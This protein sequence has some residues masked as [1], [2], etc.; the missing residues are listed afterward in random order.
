MLLGMGGAKSEEVP[1]TVGDAKAAF[2]AAYGAPVGSM[3]QGFVNEMLTSVTLATVSA[4]Y[5]YTRVF[6]VGFETLCESFLAAV[7][8]EAQRSKIH[9]A[10]C[11]ALELDA[12]KVVQDAAA[13][14]E[15]AGSMTEEQIL[16][17]ADLKSGVKYSYPL[18]AGLLTLMPLVGSPPST[19]VID[20]WCEALGLTPIRLQKDWMFFEKALQQMADGR[21]M[22]LEM[23]A[24]AKR[25][26]AAT[27]K[28]KADKAAEEAKAAE[29]TEE[30]TEESAPPPAAA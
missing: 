26:E 24:S 6:A 9:D 4:D 27:L 28:A 13:L 15:A 5:K 29:A 22:M 14:K 17:T 16:A 8:N 19:D 20:R 21:Q 10:M 12:K 1:R 25:K 3:S 11:V 23:Q 7:P 2:Q 18:G 30:A